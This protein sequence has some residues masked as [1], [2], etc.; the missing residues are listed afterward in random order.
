MKLNF[1]ISLVLKGEIKKKK[2]KKELESILVNILNTQPRT[3]YH[4]NFIEIK[5]FFKYEFPTNPMMR[6]EVFF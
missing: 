3:W 6:D 5:V 2:L 1:T 4:N